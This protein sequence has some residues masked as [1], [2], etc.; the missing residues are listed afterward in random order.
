MDEW[1][2]MLTGETRI[3]TQARHYENRASVR[4]EKDEC[5]AAKEEAI[6]V[7]ECI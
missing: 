6:E 5:E 7:G 3:T 4:R 1:M 2:E